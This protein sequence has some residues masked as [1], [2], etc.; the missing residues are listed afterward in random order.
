MA[1]G[2][3]G[4]WGCRKEHIGEIVRGMYQAPGRVQEHHPSRTTRLELGIGQA[5]L[6]RFRTPCKSPLTCSSAGLSASRNVR[7]L[8]P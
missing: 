2:S 8:C 3:G 5:C 6:V 1:S 7:Y 4:R